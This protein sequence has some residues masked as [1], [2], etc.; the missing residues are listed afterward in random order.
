MGFSMVRRRAKHTRGSGPTLTVSRNQGGS[1]VLQIL[2]TT[3]TP[4]EIRHAI[5]SST[6]ACAPSLF[7]L[8]ADLAH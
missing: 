4:F 1:I 7:Q 3:F 6:S 2:V 8:R 5:V